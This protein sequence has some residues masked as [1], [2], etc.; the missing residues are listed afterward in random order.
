MAYSEEDKRLLWEVSEPTLKLHTPVFDVM[1]Q[2]EVAANGVEGDYITLKARDW[3]MVIPVIEDDFIM[4]R[5]WRHSLKA[6]TTEF[7]G[8]V[9]DPDEDISV[10]ALRELEE[11]T[12]YKVGK[13]TKL[14]AINPN[15]A[16]FSNTFHIFLAEDLEATGSQH[17][18]HDELLSI[19]RIP[20]KEVISGYGNEDYQHGLMGTAL[21]FYLRHVMNKES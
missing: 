8:G 14:G 21:A 13:L 16:L 15:P 5:Q 4:V 12:G 20:I 2:H 3:A 7:P 11:E 9:A 18:D 6:L 10:S 17:L 1:T 19:K